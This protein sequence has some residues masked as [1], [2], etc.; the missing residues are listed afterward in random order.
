MLSIVLA[1]LLGIGFTV[2]ASQNPANISLSVFDTI[3]TMPLYLFGALS[4][5]LGIFLSTLFHLF[6]FA[7]TATEINTRDTQLRN[8]AKTNENLQYQLQKLTDENM[9]L[10]NELGVERT[11]LR[12]E[13]VENTKQGIRNFFSRIR[14]SF[15]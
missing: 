1:I 2:V 9:R 13:R 11:A 7:G 14:H 4:F 3:L 15:N 10:R 5:L 12:E 8:V 6:D